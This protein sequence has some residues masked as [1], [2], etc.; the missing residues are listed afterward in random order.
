MLFNLSHIPTKDI[1]ILYWLASRADAEAKAEQEE[2]D[3]QDEE[4][5]DD[6]ETTDEA[7]DRKRNFP[8]KSK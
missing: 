1:P 5:D 3:R 7:T 6:G 8:R 4:E 2:Q